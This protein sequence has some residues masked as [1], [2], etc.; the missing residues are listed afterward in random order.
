MSDKDFDTDFQAMLD[1]FV[2]IPGGFSEDVLENLT[3][4]QLL[5]IQKKINPYGAQMNYGDEKTRQVIASYTNLREDYMRRFT[6]TSLVGFLFRIHDEWEVPREARRW[7]L[8][9]KGKKE[10]KN[11]DLVRGFDH[12]D[13]MS[14]AKEMMKI[15]ETAKERYE[16]SEELRMAA[17]ELD[18]EFRALDIEGDASKAEEKKAAEKKLMDALKEA[19]NAKA[20]LQ[21]VLYAGAR[22]LYRFGKEADRRIDSNL[23][24]AKKF[25][26]ITKMLADDPLEQDRVPAS[27]QEVPKKVAK[28]II[29]NFIR[30]W[31][32]FNP[33]AHVRS[34]HNEVVVDEALEERPEIYP[35]VAP[36]PKVDAAD[37]ERVPLSELTR[38]WEVAEGDRD[39]Y[40]VLTESESAANVALLYLRDADIR[41]ALAHASSNYRTRQRFLRYLAPRDRQVAKVFRVVPPQDTFHRW[42]YYTEVN[43]DKLRAAVETLYEEKPDLDWAILIY[44]YIEGS[45][46]EVQK[47]YTDFVARKQGEVPTAIKMFDVGNWVL[48]SD[49]KENREKIEFLNKNTTVLKRIFDRH[50]EDKK[51]GSELMKNRIRQAKAKNIE[52][53]GPDAPRLKEYRGQADRVGM[54]GA[55]KVISTAEMKRLEAARGDIKAAKELEAHDQYEEIV[56]RL[57]SAEK[58]RKLLPDEARELAEA[59]KDLAMAKEMLEVPDDAIQIDVWTHDSAKGSFGK[60]KMYTKAVAP[61]VDDDTGPM[62]KDST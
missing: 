47:K 20:A 5:E 32:E 34:A 56:N 26:Q 6:M 36:P 12:D 31:F 4:E 42:G 57:E 13:L 61:V 50:A 62:K 39:A 14:R 22:T 8:K 51:M 18:V 29:T 10:Y 11:A 59:R 30:H 2:H 43:F 35:G 48:L 44:D 55:E 27:Q 33:D 28:G 60:Q 7:T 58:L 16:R 41:K 25:P 15:A 23:E 45:P 40:E 54:M 37:P 53:A 38:K 24:E 21:G 9:K 1:D 3:D 52:E 46:E 49:F 19:D 17:N